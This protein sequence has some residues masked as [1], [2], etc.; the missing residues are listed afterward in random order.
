MTDATAAGGHAKGVQAADLL[1]KGG[2]VLDVF[3]GRMVSADVAVANGMIVGFR[4]QQ[5]R[6][7]VDLD[8]ACV[9]PGFVD[10]HVHLESAQ[11]TPREFAKAVLP[12]GTTTVI[13]DPHE[14]ANVL[15]EDGV[16]YMLKASEGLP[17]NVHVMVPSCVPAS[18]LSTAGAALDASSVRAMLRWPRVLG[19]G[20][21]M[22]YPGVLHGDPEVLAKLD[23]AQGRCIDGHA[24]GLRG[25]DLWAYVL[26]GP[27]TDHECTD[28]EE[29]REKLQC[30]MHILIREG[31][32][33]RN[34]HTL[35]PLLSWA[36]APQVHFCTD[37]RHP[38]TLEEEG[39]LDGILR[40]AIDAGAQPELV[41]TAASLHAARCYGLER[42]GAVAPGYRADLVV[43]EDLSGVRIRQVYAGGMLV[44][45]QGTCVAPMPPPVPHPSKRMS[46]DPQA[47]PLTLAAQEGPARVIGVVP[48]QVVTYAQ[49]RHPKITNGEVVA[50]LENDVLKAAV[51]ERHH[52]TAS[53]GL[54]LVHGFGL[55]RGALAS[56]VAHDAHNL[57]VVGT[58]DAE[59]HTAIELLTRQ[60]G[61]QVVVDRGRVLANLPLPIA[62]LMS[63]RPLGEVAQAAR[64]L[65]Q[66]AAQLGC[67]LPDPFMSLSFLAL[68]VIPQLKLTD[69]GIV[70]VD[71]F[72]F[73]PLFEADETSG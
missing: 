69:R 58:D 35:L 39:H 44:A 17:L 56:T 7:V 1:L 14:I 57:I 8:G 52:G 11:V 23:T 25:P 54:G 53:V 31:T 9:V 4:A 5:A 46:L 22:N 42:I 55:R 62:G 2:T 48:D 38:P 6:R 49:S 18:P 68:E 65:Q 64:E 28:L 21:M 30:G 34:L 16:H 10:T 63:D 61:G 51:V 43:L 33:A 50:D 59:M 45:D 40:A 36:T 71:L 32:T 27:R 60:G 67:Q 73:V 66:A 12:R 3:S 26:A 47:V 15:G 37:D 70:D 20:E 41:F 29:A 19:L 24:P 13:A 72:R